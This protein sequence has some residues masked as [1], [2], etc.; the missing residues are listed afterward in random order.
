MWLLYVALSC[1]FLLTAY[2]FVLP[3]SKKR[4]VLI[5]HKGL[6]AYVAVIAI[7]LF[8]LTELLPLVFLFAGAILF[9]LL[10]K[11]WF[12]YGINQ[13]M[14]TDAL[15]RAASLTRVPLEKTGKNYYIN[16]S[17]QVSIHYSVGKINIISFKEAEESKKARITVEVMRKFIHNYFI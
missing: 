4:P 10:F 5:K 17:L 16:G 6:I 2:F 13:E 15:A 3:L 14:I 9:L 7:S 12:V 8:L 1:F 11:P